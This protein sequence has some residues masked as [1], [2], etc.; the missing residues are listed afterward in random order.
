VV[1]VFVV[2]KDQSLVSISAQIPLYPLEP[3]IVR[4][5]INSL[6][7]SANADKIWKSNF[8]NGPFENRNFLTTNSG[9]VFI[10]DILLIL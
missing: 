2:G 1:Q 5:R 6:S 7:N 4:A 10:L 3:S 9:F 8:S